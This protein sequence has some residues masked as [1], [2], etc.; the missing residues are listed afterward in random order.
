MTH[1]LHKMQHVLHHKRSQTLRRS[2]AHFRAIF[3][4]FA[5][6]N[7]TCMQT[8]AQTQHTKT[9][10]YIQNT[11]IYI[12]THTT[13]DTAQMPH[14]Y[15]CMLPRSI[16]HT[17]RVGESPNL[18][19]GVLILLLVRNGA[20]PLLAVPLVSI[21]PYSCWQ[22]VCVFCKVGACIRKIMMSGRH[23]MRRSPREYCH[24][25][26]TTTHPNKTTK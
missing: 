2:S 4:F 15:V 1:A 18:A 26:Q 10:T 8:H 12:Y 14:I 7:P 17:G 13:D 11:Y 5:K 6:R 23:Q 19:D 25:R 16:T 24:G 3:F 21:L 20:A 9:H 22:Y